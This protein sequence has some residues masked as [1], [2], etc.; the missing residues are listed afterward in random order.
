MSAPGPQCDSCGTRDDVALAILASKGVIAPPGRTLTYAAANAPQQHR[1]P[2]YCE[3]CLD[4]LNAIVREKRAQLEQT[5]AAEAVAGSGD[6]V[7]S[8]A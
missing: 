8:P 5:T 3:R 2:L 7:P 6:G 4:A 1:G